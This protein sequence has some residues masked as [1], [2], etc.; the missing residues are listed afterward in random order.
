M[1]RAAKKAATTPAPRIH[2]ELVAAIN[3]PKVSKKP[4][5]I[6][7]EKA[8]RRKSKR[9]NLI[10]ARSIDSVIDQTRVA[11]SVSVIGSMVGIVLGGSIPLICY[12]I[13][14]HEWTEWLSV[15]TLLVCGGLIF[16]AKT[17]FGWGK[18]A[19][20]DSYKALG[21]ILLVEGTMVFSSIRWI[22]LLCLAILI[23]VNAVSTGANLVIK[24]QKKPSW[25]T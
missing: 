13:A 6:P 23:G 22:N 25:E 5:P 12:T 19:F 8:P 11:F 9:I 17:V 16:S 2:P 21:F 18:A 14:H 3:K 20:R 10:S 7:K 15:Y 4:K 1:T 24:P